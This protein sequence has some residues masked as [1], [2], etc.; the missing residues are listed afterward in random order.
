MRI[1]PAL[2]ALPLAAQVP[3][4]G[5]AYRPEVPRPQVGRAYTSDAALAA[6]LEGIASARDRV[7]AFT[8]NVTEE[9]RPQV[10]LAISSPENIARLDALKADNARLAD[11]RSLSEAGARA[12]AA[13]NPAFVWLGYSIHGAEPAG[14]EAALAVAYHFAA[15]QDPEVLE[16]LGRTVLLLDVAQNP[17]G[18]ARHLQA[19]AEVTQGSN[20]PDPQDAQ[21]Q[22]RWPS[23]RFNH[24]LFDLN[25]DWAWQTQGET[26]A[27]AALFLSWNP[28]VL[29]DHHE[30]KPEGNYFFPPGMAPVHQG[31]GAA[32][33]GAWQKT[34]GDAL[35][36]AFDAQGFA[37]F[38]R[39]VFDLFYPGYGDSWGSFQG[40]V[41]MTFECPSPG[42]LAYLRKDG[43]L[44]TLEAR[45]RRHFT[46]SL[47]TVSVAAARREELLLDYQR[48]R[49]ERLQAKGAFLL[50]A[51]ADPGR[52]L[53]LVR[54]LRRNGIE[55]LRTTGEVPVAG[56]EAVL[57]GE[58]PARIPAGSYLVP[59]DQPRGGLAEA[60]LERR[61]AF[62]PKPSY[63]ATAWSLP[64][65]FNVPAW[66]APVRPAVG[67]EPLRETPVAPL[68][69]AGYA[70]LVSSGAEGRERVLEGLL[71]DGF[72]GSALPEP[73]VA[74]GRAYPAGTAVFT[75]L[76][77]DASRLEARARELAAQAPGVLGTVDS[78]AVDSGPDLG[79]SRSLP[80]RAPRVGLVM[81]APADPT[82]VGA[83]M[84]TLLDA[85]IPFTQV[86]A[87]RLAQAD[88]RRYSHLIL[89]DD[90]GLGAKWQA[91]LGP[92]GAARLKAYAQ[93]GGVLLALQGGS[94]YAARAGISEAGV[95]FLARKDE[96]ARLREK[97]PK[98]EA[99]PP[100][101]QERAQAW[102][103]REDQALRETIPGAMLRAEIDGTH[104]LGWGLNATEGAVL[105]SSDPVLELSPG[106]ENP[107]R[108]GGGDLN[109]SGL[110]P[111]PLEAKVRQSAY[112]LRE[113]KGRG[114]VILFSGDPVHRGCAPFTARAFHNAL[115]FGAYAPQDDED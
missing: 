87:S 64:L 56:L 108:F 96:E 58:P 62:G 3:Y 112:A 78:S 51:G 39:E 66:R 16:Q 8:Y 23:G 94:A 74:G 81:D 69:R 103:Q 34:F 32:F 21:N 100:A 71:K 86:R 7:R 80:L 79:S 104:P 95:S 36:R 26:R 114:A 28:Q 35:G 82:A 91:L 77:N 68:P 6:A 22:A 29:A 44:L 63:D 50:A 18:R 72:R 54:T 84:Q 24:R 88:L 10:L 59:L 37:Y 49:R 60:L 76:R 92:A 38:T 41:G 90:S 99:V 48:V 5:R 97:D 73:F 14:T 46:A 98:R 55:V 2:V 57:P 65:A 11:P 33:G 30:M 85:G 27:K 102:A 89:P 17:D 42:G 20:P 111:R 9:G 93:D 75:L 101:L 105:D 70:Y 15:C 115:F 107:L 31:L 45:V 43:D 19:V 67:T 25:R 61:A 53:A 47:A 109:L 110:L 1:L 106:G 40:A 83:V 12:L 52:A 4:P 113:R 13:R